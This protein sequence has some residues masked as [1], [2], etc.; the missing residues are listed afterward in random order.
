MEV[1]IILQFIMNN[2]RKF[3]IFETE[4]QT[5]FIDRLKKIMQS[6]C[7]FIKDLRWQRKNYK[8]PQKIEFWILNIL[9]L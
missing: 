6:N 2:L 4:S 3:D 1:G 8:L 7:W 5:V 9:Y